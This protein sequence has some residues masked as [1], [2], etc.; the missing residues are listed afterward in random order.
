MSRVAI[1]M[2]AA[3]I[4]LG[5]RPD[6]A[7]AQSARPVSDDVVHEIAAQLRCVVCQNLAVADSPSEMASQMRAIIRERL[8]AGESPAE[9]K[10]YALGAIRELEFEHTAGH[11]SDADFTELRARYE[12]EAATILTELDRLGPAEP[13]PARMAP[14]AVPRRSAWR[15]PAALATAAVLLVVFGIAVGAGIVRCTEPDPKAAPPS[16]GSR[17]R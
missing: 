4:L 6:P 7:S 12:G 17:P 8:A 2:F 10:R 11:V 3:L 9:D 15:H 5:A 1:M 13:A 14:S 16:R